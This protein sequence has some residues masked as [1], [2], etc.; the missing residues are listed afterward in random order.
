MEYKF[1]V[2]CSKSKLGEIREFLQRVLSENSIPE[3]TVNTLV[4][5]V[6]E[7]CANLI[8][9]SHNCNPNDQLELK[10]RVN[11][12]SEITFDIIDH[13]DGFNIGNYQEPSISDIVKQK[14]KGGIGL[15]LVRR[16]MD[17]IELIK[18]EKKN[19]YRLHKKI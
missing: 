5:A 12:K 7:V 9:H 2:P 8:I 15:M 3:V 1:K 14:R 17:E 6:D 18:G 10:V 19:V 16:I 4:L 13:G 11:G